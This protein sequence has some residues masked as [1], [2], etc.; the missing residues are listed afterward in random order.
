M[1]DDMLKK[2]PPFAVFVSEFDFLAKDGRVF[3]ERGKKVGKLLDIS[4]LPSAG[5]GLEGEPNDSETMKLFWADQ[6]L[7]FDLWVRK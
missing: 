6:C 1:P 4:D 5:H 7:G 2:L 3:A